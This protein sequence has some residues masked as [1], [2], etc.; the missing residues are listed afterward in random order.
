[1][2]IHCGLWNVPNQQHFKAV[3]LK[4]ISEYN[5]WVWLSLTGSEWNV[6]WVARQKYHLFFFF[7]NT[8]GNVDVDVEISV[9]S[10]KLILTK[11]V[12]KYFSIMKSRVMIALIS[13]S[14][15]KPVKIYCC[16]I[17]GWWTRCKHLVGKSIILS[18]YYLNL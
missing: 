7:S 8:V 18:A 1:M 3:K 14:T 16:F 2:Y 6:F 15:W 9:C 11:P 12:H 10:T 5:L 4:L 13:S 17:I